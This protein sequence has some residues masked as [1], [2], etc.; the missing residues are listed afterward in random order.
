MSA[1]ATLVN[2]CR[3]LG[4]KL[5]VEANGWYWSDTTGSYGPY[6]TKMQ[7]ALN[8]LETQEQQP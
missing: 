7:A 8:A 4:I 6:L 1:L 3:K 2:R 5:A